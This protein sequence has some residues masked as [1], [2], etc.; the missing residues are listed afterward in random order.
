MFEDMKKKPCH[1]IQQIAKFIE[2]N[3][4]D[5]IVDK[6]ADLTC[7]EKMKDDKTAN[8]SWTRVFRKDGKP[9]FMRK[10]IVG[11]WKNHLSDEQSAEMDAICDRRLKGMGI[12]FQYE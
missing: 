8:M 10:G 4:S 2:V 9:T 3:L 11:D 6:I 5:D 7:F 12:E 1:A